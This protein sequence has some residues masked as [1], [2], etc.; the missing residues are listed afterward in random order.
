M[1]KQ[2][3]NAKDI[4]ELMQVKQTKSYQVIRKVNEKLEA[5]GF[6]VL[7]GRVSARAVYE[8]FGLEKQE[9]NK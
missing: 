4:Q 9:D 8:Y 3:L 6:L 1:E 5:E 7:R 2:F